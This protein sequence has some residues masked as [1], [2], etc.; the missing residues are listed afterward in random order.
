MLNDAIFISSKQ[1]SKQKHPSWW[2]QH[3]NITHL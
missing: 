3:T 1:V 2:P